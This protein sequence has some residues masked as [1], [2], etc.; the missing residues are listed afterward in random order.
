MKRVCNGCGEYVG[1]VTDAE[2]DC[3]AEGHPLPDVRGECAHCAPVVEAETAGCRTWQL[4]PQSF[5]RVMDEIDRLR[6][7][8][9]TKGYTRGV[10]PMQRLTTVGLR[11]GQRPDHVVAF[12]G[13][14]IIRHPNG[15]FTVHKAPAAIRCNNCATVDGPFVEGGM[16]EGCAQAVSP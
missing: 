3:A 11:V 8:V 13:D 4:T 6:P 1:D 7:W 12:W 16:C 9:F 15:T 5:L 14:W 2:L 10:G